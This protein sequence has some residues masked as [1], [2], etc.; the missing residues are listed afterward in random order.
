MKITLIFAI[1]SVISQFDV[2]ESADILFIAPL[3]SKSHKNFFDGIIK[4]LAQKGH[5]VS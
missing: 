1:F 2:G 3:G 4:G 5:K